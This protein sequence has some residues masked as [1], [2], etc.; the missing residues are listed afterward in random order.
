MQM[1]DVS[2]AEGGR[3]D[4]S[5]SERTFRLYLTDI[6]ETVFLPK[7]MA[8]LAREAPRVRIEAHQLDLVELTPALESGRL[9]LALGYLPSLDLERTVLWR[10]R[11]AVVMREGHPFA[12]L[13]PSVDSL[14]RLEY[15]L[16][17]AHPA[18]ARALHDLGLA[19][20]VRLSIPHFMVL[21]R[22]L[23]ETDLAVLMPPRLYAEFARLGRY[24][25][26][27]PRIGLP[28]L[29]VAVHWVARYAGDPGLRWLKER[30]V[31]L[32]R[33]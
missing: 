14:R 20:R 25:M 3:Y 17:R 1:I 19:D 2:A 16:V 23:A 9:D 4:P 10:E 24:A 28:P 6:G 11:Y 22:I 12:R 31:Q 30:I 26:W 15:A 13:R 27:R 8:A 21:P 32:F 18:T 29:D 5:R 33:E 7:L